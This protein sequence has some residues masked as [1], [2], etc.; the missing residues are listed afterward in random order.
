VLLIM[1]LGSSSRQKRELSRAQDKV[2][3]ACG[4]GHPT[5]AQFCR[6]C[7]KKL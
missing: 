7:G 6:K 2:C 4:S 1:I 3:G 5:F